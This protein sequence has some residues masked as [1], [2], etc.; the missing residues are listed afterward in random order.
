MNKKAIIFYWPHNRPLMHDGDEFRRQALVCKKW[1][2]ANGYSVDMREIPKG[3]AYVRRNYVMSQ[4]AP[5]GH[6]E[7]HRVIFLCHGSSKSFGAGFNV[8][9]VSMLADRLSKSNAIITLFCCLT[10]KKQVGGLAEVLSTDS[11]L[12]V[13][14]H[15]TRGH[16]T[17]NPFKRV[18]F[19]GKMANLYPENR[20]GIKKLKKH[21][22]SDDS[23]P[24]AFLED[25][26]TSFA[27]M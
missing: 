4:L 18:F 11:G 6:N 1:Y 17:C 26:V 12:M 22:R 25:F 3:R 9:N 19:R 5:Y 13:F 8:S 21:F 2:K 16:T 10:G 27:G 14:A 24:I 23:A 20:D 15:K 7:L